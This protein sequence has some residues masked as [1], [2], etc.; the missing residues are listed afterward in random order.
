MRLPSAIGLPFL[1]LVILAV[2]LLLLG[3]VLEYRRSLLLRQPWRLLTGHF[4]HVSLV[5]AMLNAVALLLLARLFDNRLDRSEIGWMLLVAPLLISM[6]F[7]I[8]MPGLAWYRGLS[9]TLH[10]IYFAGCVVWIGASRGRARWLPIAAL[11]AGS[12]KLLLEQPW[13][14]SFP[15]REWLTATVVPQAHLIGAVIGTVAGLGI[16]R[17][18]GRRGSV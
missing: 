6:V 1:I 5:H 3:D 12:A 18:R 14:Q 13:D 8:A 10:A 17:N 7:W 4:V 11:V 2:E 16:A 9:G 15:Y